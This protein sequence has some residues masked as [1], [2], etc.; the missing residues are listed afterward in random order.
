MYVNKV[1]E[2]IGYGGLMSQLGRPDH[3]RYEK[4]HING[5]RSGRPGGT[6]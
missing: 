4:S 1:R 3:S 5:G 6:S 2:K